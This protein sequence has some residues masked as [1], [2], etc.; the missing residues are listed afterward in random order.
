[1][2]R[3]NNP[4]PVILLILTAAIASLP[5]AECRGEASRYGGAYLSAAGDTLALPGEVFVVT[6]EEL[7]RF[8]INT[9]EDIIEHLPGVSV[10]QGGP[11]GSKTLYTIDGRTVRGMTLLVNGVPYNDPYNEDPLARFLT[12]SRV[13][14]V[15]VIYSSSP[16]LT[17]R[18]SSGGVINIVVEEGGRKPPVTAGDFTWG[19]NGR[20][21]RK[22]WFSSPDAF[23]NGTITYD[24]Y[25]QDYFESVVDEPSAR[26]GEYNSRSVMLELTLRGKADDRVLVRLRRFEDSY[27]GTRNWP[28]RRDLLRPPES[29]RYSGLDSEVRYVRGGAEV[30]LRQRLVEMKRKAGWTSGL[31]FG[32]AVTWHGLAGSTAVKGFVTAE[33]AAFENRLWGEPFSPDVDRAEGGL[34]LGGDTGHLRWRGGISAG[35]M[36]GSGFFAGGEAALSRGNEKGLYQ[37]LI[38]ARRVRTPTT[39]ELYQPDLEYLPNGDSL[40]TAG[41]P[42]LGHETSDEISLG[43]GYGTVVTTDIFVRF[44]RSR[45]SLDG[46]DPAVYMSDGSDDVIG[47]RASLRGGGSTGIASFSY[48][49]QLRGYWFADRAEITPGVPEYY[50]RAGL[51]LSRPSFKKTEHFIIGVHAS[52]TG[53]RFFYGVELGRYTLLDLSVSLTVLGAVAKFEMKNILDEKYETVPGMYMPGKHYRFGI[54]WRL[55]D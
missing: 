28:E 27:N 48:N 26:V 42:G 41:N 36:T 44:E 7:A 12:L 32:G 49:W 5:A 38:V 4:L 11:P 33:R 46:S 17:G 22:A 19:G 55:F 52:E 18:A 16:S 23:I 45:I 25:M 29:V 40:N 2:T 13:R 54:N 53:S 24:E 30:S 39:E 15:E 14:R 20:K 6:A 31:V 43:L 1:M 51:W 47:L 9:I 8:D 50:A 35:S 21:S 3:L 34:T 10:L 37:T